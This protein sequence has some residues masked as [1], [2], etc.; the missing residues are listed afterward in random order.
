MGYPR[1]SHVNAKLWSPLQFQTMPE[2]HFGLD[3]EGEE[4][5]EICNT[6]RNRILGDASSRRLVSDT[7][8]S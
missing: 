3:S 8:E 4:K 1:G 5:D 7:A 2:A 6:V